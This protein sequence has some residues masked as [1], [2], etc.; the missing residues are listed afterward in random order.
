[1]YTG[2]YDAG[3]ETALEIGEGEC[4]VWLSTYGET[5][6]SSLRSH[7][8]KCVIAG[9]TVNVGQAGSPKTQR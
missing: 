7:P 2:G 6:H 1:M 5:R 8:I 3:Y 4:R 9:P